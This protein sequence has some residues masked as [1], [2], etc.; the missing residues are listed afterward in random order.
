MFFFI[1]YVKVFIKVVVKICVFWRS[2][3][4]KLLVYFCYIFW[5]LGNY[6]VIFINGGI[7]DIYIY[8]LVFVMKLLFIIVLVIIRILR[9]F[10]SRFKWI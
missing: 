7:F 2:G 6:F 9:L 5:I 8:I 3:I 10:I 1:K 4:W